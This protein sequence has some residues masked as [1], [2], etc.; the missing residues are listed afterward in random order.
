MRVSDKNLRNGS[1]PCDF[2]HVRAL[3]GVGINA[4]F[5]NVLY[6][7]GFKD[8]LGLNAV[9]THGGGVHLDGLH[10]IYKVVFEV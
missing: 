9:R 3:V 8:A 2:H 6:A 10:T 4:D 5:F 7:L 1:P